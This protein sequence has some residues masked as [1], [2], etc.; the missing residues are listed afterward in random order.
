MVVSFL[1]G[2]QQRRVEFLAKIGHVVLRDFYESHVP[3]PGERPR[4]LTLPPLLPRLARSGITPGLNLPGTRPGPA[5]RRPA[6]RGV[7]QPLPPRGRASSVLERPRGAGAWREC[8]A[9]S[10]LCRS[11]PVLK[12]AEPR[13]FRGVQTRVSPPGCG[14]QAERL[15]S[16]RGTTACRAGAVSR[17]SRAACAGPRS[18]SS[19]PRRCPPTETSFT[20]GGPAGELWAA[21]GHRELARASGRGWLPGLA[22]VS[23]LNFP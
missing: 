7:A 11:L 21:R 9:G 14:L 8:G 3:E 13:A 22:L 5:Q 18:S 20:R 15:P 23:L 10:R 2:T 1:F 6:P 17:V 4:L 16:R 12:E 19:R